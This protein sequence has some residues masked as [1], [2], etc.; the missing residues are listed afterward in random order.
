MFPKKLFLLVCISVFIPLS[1]FTQATTSLSG[2]VSDKSG[3]IV[4][5]ANVKLASATTNA[6]RETA[7]DAN[8]EF[9]FSQLAPGRYNLRI[10]MQG[11][12]PNE[13]NEMDLLVG[14]AV[15]VNVTLSVAS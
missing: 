12:E 9:Q 11:F 15:T 8:G 14:Q 7:T 2:R 4:P 13:K 10:T 3:A 1:G 5:G 6:S